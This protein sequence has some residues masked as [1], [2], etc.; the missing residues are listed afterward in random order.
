LVAKTS[1]VLDI[2]TRVMVAVWELTKNDLLLCVTPD[3]IADEVKR[4]YG[5]KVALGTVKN[6]FSELQ[7]PDLPNR[8]FHEE[9]FHISTNKMGKARKRY[10]L[11]EDLVI[12]PETAF[13]LLELARRGKGH[14]VS[15]GAIVEVKH[16]ISRYGV[17]EADVETRISEAIRVGYIKGNIG[18]SLTVCN[19]LR[20][21]K[22][23]LQEL[24][25]RLVTL[26]VLPPSEPATKELTATHSKKRGLNKDACSTSEIG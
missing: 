2:R 19:R 18:G 6:V 10:C 15:P 24:H 9:G 1:R 13:I 17:T 23:Y 16:E 3:E 8:I 7:K 4:L 12:L 14:R 26:S 21:E 25:N 11:D 5:K 22:E 20:S